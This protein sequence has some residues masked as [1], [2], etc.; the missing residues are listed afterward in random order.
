MME[1][2]VIRGLSSASEGFV[3][4][5]FFLHFANLTPLGKENSGY[6]ML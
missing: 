3:F 2:I 1:K 5:W 4:E 6:P